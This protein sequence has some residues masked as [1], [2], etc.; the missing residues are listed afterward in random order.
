MGN[1][2][3]WLVKGSYGKGAENREDWGRDRGVGQRGRDNSDYTSVKLG[4]RVGIAAL[5]VK[6]PSTTPASPMS[7]G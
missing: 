4:L 1:W 3:D 5:W 7:T 6:A 2:R